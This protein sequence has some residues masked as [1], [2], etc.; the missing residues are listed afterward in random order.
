MFLRCKTKL[1]VLWDNRDMPVKDL[2][3]Y[4]SKLRMVFCEK[5]EESYRYI[6]P[7]AVS[8]TEK[9]K[10]NKET[11]IKA[12][13]P[14]CFIALGFYTCTSSQRIVLQ[15]VSDIFEI[16][17][18]IRNN[19]AQKPDYWGLSTQTAIKEKYIPERFIKDQKIIL[20]SGNEA[21]VGDGVDADTVMP[22]A[23]SFDIVLPKLNKAQCIAH[24]EAA[25]SSENQVKLLKISVAN[26][27]GI[28]PFEWGGGRYSLP[29]AKYAS[30]DV[31]ADSDNTVIWSLK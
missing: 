28:Y 23:L 14:F 6:L 11:L 10:E 22:R 2:Q 26:A 8:L 4:L 12:F 1:P 18:E 24:T 3:Q 27:S 31:C 16:S 17:D 13:I 25:I 5:Y 15:N 29:V 9:A 21:F 20:S 30:K 7:R 19:Y